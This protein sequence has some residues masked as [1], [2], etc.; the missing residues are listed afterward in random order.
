ML[1]RTAARWRLGADQV[2]KLGSVT[3]PRV[4][5]LLGVKAKQSG[6][7]RE[8]EKS[9]DHLCGDFVVDRGG[10]AIAGRQCKVK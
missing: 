3:L 8:W 2:R 1:L 5:S 10:G 7:N 4:A 9:V 6:F